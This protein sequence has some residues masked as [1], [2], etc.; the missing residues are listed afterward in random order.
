MA[1]VNHS[2]LAVRICHEAVVR[3]EVM[4]SLVKEARA[5]FEAAGR[6]SGAGEH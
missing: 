2:V 1:A 5:V 4:V 3:V 6:N